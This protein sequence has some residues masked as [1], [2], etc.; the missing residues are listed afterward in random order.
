MNNR[1][2]SIRISISFF[3]WISIFWLHAASASEL[4]PIPAAPTIE[5]SSYILMDAANGAVLTQLNAD[6]RLPPASVT[7]IMTS[8]LVEK[9]IQSKK[10]KPTD[11]VLISVNAWRQSGSRMFVQEGTSV[12]VSD[13]LKGIIIQSGN[14]ASVA[15]AEH[16]AG[17]EAAFADLMN[18]Q[19]KE[20]GMLNSHFMNATGLPHPEHYT[21]ARDLAILSRNL[22]KRFPEHYSIYK[23]KEFTFNNIVQHNRNLLL[24]RDASVDGIKTGHTDEAGYCLVASALRN[25]T[26]LIAVIMGSTSP[27]KR[28]DEAQT[29]LNYGFRFFETRVIY[30]KDQSLQKPKVWLGK[31]DQVSVGAAEPVMIT[32][33]RGQEKAI[34]TEINVDA[35][36]HAPI[37]KG[38]VLGNI[39]LSFNGET[40]REI[41]LVAQEN[42]EEAGFFK[43]IWQHIYLFFYGFFTKK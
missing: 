13:L 1:F 29:L 17:S 39:I 33:P 22:I 14:D 32:I 7:K 23:Q 37:K 19:A 4:S 21:T 20:L 25:D 38:Q 40:Q 30:K 36:I 8:Y 15:M 26:R 6:Q 24:Y 31:T 41:P 28:A 42:I 35:N 3:I 34:S 16:I 9:E 27:T 5:A 43:R 12:A 11:Q 2:I 18:F 10:I